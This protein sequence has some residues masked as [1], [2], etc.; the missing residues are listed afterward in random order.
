MAVK[1]TI[2]NVNIPDA[3]TLS[4]HPACKFIMDFLRMIIVDSLSLPQSNKLPPVIDLILEVSP[5]NSTRHQRRVFQT[6]VLN[7]LMDHLL[8]ADVL[9]GEQAALPVAVG[10]SYVHMANNVFYLAGRVVDKLWQVMPGD[11]TLTQL[12]FGDIE[13]LPPP[14]AYYIICRIVDALWTGAY[15]RDPK[16][17]F[18]FISKLISQAKRKASGVSLDGIY[19]CLNRTILFQLSRPM[20]TV[21]DHTNILEALH[22]LTENRTLIFGPGNF[23]QEFFG[24]LCYCL[25]QLTD[26]PHNIC[27]PPGLR[28]TTWHVDISSTSDTDSEDRYTDPVHSAEGLLLLATAARRVWDEL[29]ICKKPAIEEIF[30]VTLTPAEA[31]PSAKYSVP[32]LCAVRPQI[33]ETAAKIWLTYYENERKCVYSNTEKLQSQIQ[34]KLQKVGHGVLRLAQR[35]AKKEIPIKPV[36]MTSQECLV[37]TASHINIVK[38]LVEFQHKQYLQSQQH[39]E[40]YLLED[41]RAV[42]AELMRERGLWGPPVGSELDKWML[43]LT[44]GPHRMRKKMMINDQFYIN[45]P[46]RPPLDDSKP[47]KYK[48]AISNDSKKYYE[49]YRSRSLVTEELVPRNID[50]TE[51][52]LN[53]T[54]D[55]NEEM[56]DDL[57]VST[58]SLLP[59][60][61]KSKTSQSADNDDEPDID[62]SL[63]TEVGNEGE[64]QSESE[65]KTDNQTIL[66]LL[67]EGE[68]ISHMFRC[69]RIQGLD[70]MEGLLLFGKE[71]FYIVDGFT[72]LRSKEIADIDNLP[73]DMHDPIIPKT[74]KGS[75]MKKSCNKFSYEDI[76]EVHKRR[77]LLQPIAVEVFSSDG[78]NLLLACP[79]KVRNKVYARF[80]TLATGIT[81]SAH[82][83]VSGQKQNAKVEPG[84]GL[85]SSLIG[86]KSVTQRWERGEISNF[87]YLM[88]LNTLAGRSYNDL[89]QYP[90]FPWILADYQSEELNLTDPATF[91]DMSKPMG[92]QTPNRLKQ[93]NKRY[94]DWDDPQGET[95][96]YHYGTHY[97]SAMIVASY[98]VRMEPFTQIFLRLQGGHFDLADRMFHSVGDGW[99]SA[100]KHNMADVK[101]LIPEFFY[102]PEFLLNANNFDLGTKQS[103]V[104]LGDVV[105]P[106]W[107]KGDP[108]EFIRVHRQALECDYIS[109]HLNEWIDLIFGYKQQGPAA[110]EAVNVFHHLFYEGNVDIYNIDD[111]LKKSATIGFINNFGQIPKQLFKKPHPQKKLNIPK[112]IDVLPLGSMFSTHPDKL[113]FHHL[114]NLRPTMS[115]IKELKSVVGQII[116]N[117]R[118]V[119]AVEQN[120][121]LI[122]P[123]YNKYLAWGFSD[124]SL[125][126]GNYDSDKAT[127]VFENVGSGEILTAACPDC[128]TVIT[129]GTSTVVYVWEFGKG[130]DRRS[131]VLRRS[132]YG[133]TEPVTCLA[134]SAGYN[135]IVS[136]SRDRT[137]IVWDLSRLLFVRQLRGHAAP[138]AAI[139]INELTGDIATCAGTFLHV[140]SIN[141]DEIASINTA[142]GRNQQIFCVAMSQMMEWDSKNVI[143]TGNSDGV[144]RMW[145]VEFVE[146]IDD[147]KAALKQEPSTD[148]A[149]GKS[150]CTSV[151][152]STSQPQLI[153]GSRKRSV[154]E[155][156]P[157]QRS[158]VERLQDFKDPEFLT[159]KVEE[160]GSSAESDSGNAVEAMRQ[161]VESLLGEN[162]SSSF[163][164][165]NLVSN[166]DQDPNVDL[167]SFDESG[168]SFVDGVGQSKALDSDLTVAQKEVKSPTDFVMVTATDVKE[169]LSTALQGNLPTNNRSLKLR[170]GFSWQRQLVFRSKL[171]MHTAFERKDNKDPAAV[172]AIAVSKDHKTVYVG[173]AK[174]RVYSWTV[175]DQPGRVVADHW[176]KD[177]GGDSCQGCNVK[178]SFSERR[179]HCRN[180][181]QLFCS[182]CSRYET[183]IKRLRIVK[184][185]RV[186]QLCYNSLKAMQASDA[187]NKQL[188]VKA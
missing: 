167:M 35:K 43:D 29:Y 169:A 1:V 103:G 104:A 49:R 3:T 89:M 105:L 127:N 44:E 97:S 177:D 148:S 74:A 179:H 73:P 90:V 174:G 57:A 114:D 158:A 106:S 81:D 83:S 67:E 26:D 96:P 7:N 17:V 27:D 147:S 101:E 117:E 5:E 11:G 87:E 107:A 134:A 166:D 80:M 108:R 13:S 42:E 164:D 30:K 124:L 84:T 98:L 115:P 14:N 144:V 18:E 36:L 53:N 66:K 161:R 122:P 75:G 165:H 4:N 59:K 40:S 78:R 132:L 168:S 76:R 183:E 55:Q 10:G 37:W 112:N 12:A 135:I 64:G 149:D 111:P 99:L 143:M 61:T 46:Y 163:T 141:G 68:K 136:G 153:P 94:T 38:D 154:I 188:S 25:L 100:S 130:K 62:I 102:L 155:D 125:R 121:V 79:R 173:D 113:F 86:E 178:F 50:V 60:L 156:Q 186:C 92:A 128:K 175:T 145:S 88:C 72:L 9:L 146:V 69:A 22:K 33:Q 159:A 137:C 120:K 31:S 45:Y 48:M 51:E 131:L 20:Y 110:V 8:A 116:H 126:I 16:E 82:E 119:L 157:E 58:P 182:R 133:H 56:F 47:L 77:Y 140:W 54:I 41:W 171:T 65:N 162:G 34:S 93:F 172:T 150:D 2:L 176:V 39:M 160:L 52:S 85:I 151:T 19:K 170:E 28:T 118:S 91:R 152:S 138:V 70:T 95:P 139:C 129:A 187:L 15:V 63:S 109:A 71:H 123:T 6:Q 21:A 184:P 180:C 185:V 142:T 32:D 24:C 181:G 23:D